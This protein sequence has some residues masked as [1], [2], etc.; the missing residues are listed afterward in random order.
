MEAA[1]PSG[2]R[3]GRDLRTGVERHPSGIFTKGLQMPEQGPGR[4]GA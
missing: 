2:T 1:P 4:T 3:G